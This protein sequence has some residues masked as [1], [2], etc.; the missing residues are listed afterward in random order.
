M[1]IVQIEKREQL[2]VDLI[3]FE[4]CFNMVIVQIKKKKSNWYLGYKTHRELIYQMYFLSLIFFSRMTFEKN[5]FR[6]LVE[7][8]KIFSRK[9]I[10]SKN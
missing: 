8:W 5:V 2:I 1:T 9:S 10:L 6:H 4:V 3:Y 7:E